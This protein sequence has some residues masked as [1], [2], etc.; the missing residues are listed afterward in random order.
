M[1]I[2][3]S[4]PDA[5]RRAG[6][7]RREPIARAEQATGQLS[8]AQEARA[9]ARAESE[10]HPCPRC[11]APIGERCTRPPTIVETGRQPLGFLNHAERHALVD[12]AP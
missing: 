12:D 11:C 6:R 1:A 9:A 4:R 7:R 8:L 5:Y 2:H 10:R 3:F